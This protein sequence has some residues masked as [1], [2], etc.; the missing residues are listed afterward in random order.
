MAPQ[1]MNPTSVPE[2]VGSLPGLAPRVKD[3][4]LP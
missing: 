3:L 4:V 1:V 2:D